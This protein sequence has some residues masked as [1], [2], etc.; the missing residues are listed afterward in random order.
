MSNTKEFGESGVWAGWRT[1]GGDCNWEDYGGKFG[2]QDPNNARVFY[3]VKCDNMIECMGERDV[4]ESGIDTYIAQVVRVD[5]DETTGENIE[6][7]LE[8]CGLDLEEF[9]G[10]H[11][12]II[13][14]CL[15]DY[16]AAAPMGEHSHPYRADSARAKARREVE[17]LIADADQCEAMLNRPV[18]AIGSTAREYGLGDL[19]SCMDRWRVSYRPSDWLPYSFGYIAGLAGREQETGDDIV[20]E[21]FDGYR[22][23]AKVKEGKAPACSWIN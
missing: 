22:Y 23:G 5:L 21:Y 3:V 19:D 15:V 14:E 7:A 12:W 4:E 1:L 6:S 16:G 2:R 13:V 18:N 11:D 17:E 9:E 10:D 20:R 8:C